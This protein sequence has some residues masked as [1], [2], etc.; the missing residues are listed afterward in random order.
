MATLSETLI[1]RKFVAILLDCAAVGKNVVIVGGGMAGLAASIYLARGGR[2]VTIFE[3]RRYLGGRAITH[4]RHGFRLNLG[5]HAFYRG[6]AGSAVLRE[7]GIA[8]RGGVPDG[9]G[10]A[11]RG[12]ERHKFPGNSWSLITTGLWNL[13]EKIEAARLLMRVRRTR[14][15]SSV[16]AMSERQWLDEN[17]SSERVRQVIEALFRLATYCHE[18][19]KISAAAAVGQLRRA[20]RGVIYIDE[21]WQKLVDALHSSA[22]AAGVNF[23]TSSRIVALDVDAGEV[24][25]IEFGE[26]EADAQ[27]TAELRMPH[28]GRE[29]PGTRLATD[30]VLLAVDPP[31]ARELLGEMSWPPMRPVVA[32]SLDIALSRLPKPENTFALGID[33]PLYFSVHSKWAQ[34]TP[35]G[36][37]LIHVAKYG[38]GEESELEALLDEMQPG[39]R[40]VIVHRR[41]LPSMVVSNALIA[42]APATRP[43]PITPIRGLYLAGD[44]VGDIGLLSDASLA[45]A[46]T[47]ARAI[48]AA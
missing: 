38:S 34:L 41:F 23:V 32:S 30:T 24:R 31:T 29:H 16:A 8:V 33:R 35:K 25:Y 10:I 5:P 9:N 45:S 18:A 11:M 22:V 36:G 7:L 43:A 6:G 46:R 3:K 42:P 13:K 21:G 1:P 12:D 37:A 17:V 4:L 20:M 27:D 14:N 39:W 15:V 47:A 40:D 2:T 44:W 26:L 28:P 19:E 48:L